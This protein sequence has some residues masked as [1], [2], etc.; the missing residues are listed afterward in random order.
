MTSDLRLLWSGILPFHHS[1]FILTWIHFSLGLFL[2]YATILPVFFIFQLLNFVSYNLRR[3]L[4]FV[5]KS[6]QTNK[7]T[8]KRKKENK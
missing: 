7:Q 8:N 1:I 5:L 4:S 6:Q 2:N 3:D